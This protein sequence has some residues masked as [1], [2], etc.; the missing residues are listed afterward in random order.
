MDINKY[1]KN[2]SVYLRNYSQV[3]SLGRLSDTDSEFSSELTTGRDSF[4]SRAKHKKN[5][6]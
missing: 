2:R 6:K 5:S 4:S 3:L 1:S